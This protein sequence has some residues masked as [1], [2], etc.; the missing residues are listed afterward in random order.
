MLLGW[1][2]MLSRKL[3]IKNNET[4]N[5]HNSYYQTS[6][7]CLNISDII[8]LV[9]LVYEDKCDI[10]PSAVFPDIYNL[11]F[12]IHILSWN[13]LREIVKEIDTVPDLFY[14]LADRYKYLKIADIPLDEELNVLGYYKSKSNKFPSSVIDFSSSSYWHDYV[15]KMMGQILTRNVHNSFSGWI[16]ALEENFCD[17]RKLYLGYPLG[18]YFAWE[19]SSISRRERAYF[20]EKFEMVQDW[21]KEGHSDRK[22][23]FL[24][25]STGNWLLFYYS[26]SELA[27]LDKELQRLV[28]LKL[29]LEIETDSFEYA[30]YGFGFRVSKDN[31]PQ[32][33]GLSSAIFIGADYMKGKYSKADIEEARSHFGSKDQRE[34]RLIQ[35]FP[36]LE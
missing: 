10:I 16:D 17:E 12:P 27:E 34:E 31:S 26:K 13:D 36:D 29:C 24:N 6:L 30:V 20:G 28:E 3:R 23:A 11:E 35:E 4:I 14:Y 9:I 2:I 21:F 25:I 8:G 33:L 7:D 19:L 15:T 22:F 18:L 5:L 32:L 1:I